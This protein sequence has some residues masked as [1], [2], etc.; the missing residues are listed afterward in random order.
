MKSRLKA[1]RA[2]KSTC[3]D[4][5]WARWIRAGRATEDVAG[6]VAGILPF[7]PILPEQSCRR[8]ESCTGEAFLA[9]AVVAGAVADGVAGESCESVVGWGWT[10]SV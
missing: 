2:A 8:E 4:C 7:L 10:A 5:G 6:R 1:L 9:V 3:V